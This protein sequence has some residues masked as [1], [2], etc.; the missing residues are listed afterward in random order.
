VSGVWTDLS[1]EDSS[2]LRVSPT[3]ATTYRVIECDTTPSTNT[4]T[5]TPISVV[6]PTV[7]NTL[8]DTVP[9]QCG[10][11]GTAMGVVSSNSTAAT[12]EYMWFTSA[13]GFDQLDT[14]TTMF[15]LSAGGDTIYYTDTTAA[16]G[17][18]EDTTVW[19]SEVL[20]SGTASTLV[21]TEADPNTPDMLEIQNVSGR[22]LNVSGW[23]VI[24]SDDYTNINTYN[25]TTQTLSGTMSP[26][27]VTYWT[28]NTGT[29]YWGNNLFWSSGSNSWALII[30]N[31]GNVVDFVVW[32]HSATDIQS[33]SITVNSMTIT[34]GSEW[35]GA[36]INA[37][38]ASSFYRVGNMDN[39]DATDFISGG[40]DGGTQNTGLVTP[41]AG[42]VCESGR[43]RVD[44]LVGCLI[45][46]ENQA[47]E[48]SGISI[49][50]N[51]SNGLFNL[52]FNEVK[53]AMNLE[54]RDIDGKLVYEDR[55]NVNGYLNE[56]LDFTGFAKGV[57][58]LK[59]QGEE[60]STVKKLVI[61]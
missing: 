41:F 8:T 53:S 38:N 6:D 57:Y 17:S 34:P 45:G 58:F 3:A 4:F 1:G 21:I 61:Q 60:S 55:L 37:T 23:T 20:N 48:L 30:D 49:T 56:E 59:L 9:V 15:D 11:A 25:A 44:L 52:K 13:T 36:G 43:Q 7:V 27:Q 35:N 46:V 18:D 29:N 12:P 26:N 32:G 40:P 31:N 14:S 19:V 10:Q 42:G 22:T 16:L 28:D 24:V 50:P 51:P 54:V 33:M 39:N 5:V 2:I 47:A